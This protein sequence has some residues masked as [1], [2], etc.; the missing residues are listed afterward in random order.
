MEIKDQTE[1]FGRE[2]ETSNKEPDRSSINFI[3][4]HN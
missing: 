3:E 2:L 4:K 1:K